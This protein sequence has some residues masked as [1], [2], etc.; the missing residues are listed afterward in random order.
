MKVGLV[1]PMTE[2]DDGL[3]A[4]VRLRAYARQAEDGGLDSLWV[5]DHVLLRPSSGTDR[6]TWEAWTILVSLAA[7]T[8]RVELGSLV[9]CAPF[10]N[11]GLLAR[12]AL[13]M[14]E[15]S[16]GRLIL[17]V[18][19]GWHRPELELL[20][21]P[22]DHLVSRFETY[23]TALHPLLRQAWPAS[24]RPVSLLVGGDGPRLLEAAARFADSWNT[25]WLNSPAEVGDRWRAAERACR[26]VGRDPRTLAL[27]AA[28]NVSVPTPPADDPRPGASLAEVVAILDGYRAAGVAHLMCSL[29]PLTRG[30]L[31]RFA[32]AVRDHRRSSPPAPDGQPAA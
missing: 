12:M 1:L 22:F 6:W 2:S 27:T 11:P 7:A 18:G 25:S 8:S 5:S 20:G 13:T 16:G 3:L 28:A 10:R 32:R 30:T 14:Q 17:G 26:A 19:A 9:L 21:L 29:R 24:A 23:L 15:V 31:S 4:Y